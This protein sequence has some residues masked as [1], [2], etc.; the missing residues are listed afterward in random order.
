M[1]IFL[2]FIVSLFLP[3]FSFCQ[4]TWLDKNHDNYFMLQRFDILQGH[5]S[6]SLF[7]AT[8]L[9]EK[10]VLNFLNAYEEEQNDNEIELSIKEKQELDKLKKN[11]TTIANDEEEVKSEYSLGNFLYSRP[12]YLISHQGENYFIG[13]NPIIYYQQ[14]A[15]FGN[16]K[17]N[18]FVN[19]KGAEVRAS[20][21]KKV[22]F[23]SRMT[24]NQERGPSQFQRY[25]TSRG[26]VPG[27]VTYLKPFK[28]DKPGLAQD[29]ILANGYVDVEAVKNMMNISFGYDRFQNGNGYRSLLLSDFGSNYLFAK[30]NTRVWKLNYQNLFMELTPQFK[31]GA[32]ALLPKKYMAQHHLSFNAAKWLNIGFFETVVFHRKDHFE[33]QYMNPII[34]YRAIEQSL[35]SPDNALLGMD[36]KINTTRKVQ[37][38]GQVMLDE[39]K[40]SELKKGGWWANKFAL[41][42]GIKIADPLGIENMLVQFE[43]NII[44][45]FTYSYDDSLAEYSHYNQSLAHPLGANLAEAIFIVQYKPNTKTYLSLESFYNLQGR[46]SSTTGKSFGG[47]ILKSSSLRN[48]S[49][50]IKLF[51]GFKSGIF[52]ANANLAYEIKPNIFFDLG[53]LARSENASIANNPSD[54]SIYV[55]TGLRLNANRRKYNY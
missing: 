14:T 42:G 22:S 43:G 50:N 17:Q 8:P 24:D 1:R 51:N 49:N 26:A 11:N 3:L 21:G 36:F 9:T 34:F 52:Y 44:R 48:S 54:N 19:T 28:K 38:Y 5:V 53:L 15:E 4:H 23:Y 12:N 47:N 41:Q 10:N 25:I 55:Y 18:L 45:P 20:I 2:F 6:D 16:L 40:F 7:T 46:D 29:Y 32:D 27:G 13:I 35:G 33:F 39:F 31:K 30:I 37:L